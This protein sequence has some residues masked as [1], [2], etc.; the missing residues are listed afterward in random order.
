VAVPDEARTVL[1]DLTAQDLPDL[2]ARGRD[3]LAENRALDATARF[4]RAALL[5]P[6]DPERYVDLGHAL[7]ASRLERQAFAAYRT[8][9]DLAP[10]HAELTFLVADAAWRG[11]E[12]EDAMGLFARATQLDRE[13]GGAWG[14]LARGHFFAGRDDAAWRCV[15]RAEELGETI[16]PQLRERLAARTSEPVR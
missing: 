9:L 6:E 5:A 15:H 10:E 12:F 13:H 14:R 7:H 4:T 1:A 16:P 11:G 2:I 8:G 3:A